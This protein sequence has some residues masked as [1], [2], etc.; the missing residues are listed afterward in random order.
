[1]ELEH[2]SEESFLLEKVY[3]S[4]RSSEGLDLDL[5]KDKELFKPLHEKWI[6]DGFAYKNNQNKVILTS[7][8]Y[9]LLDSLMNDLF[10]LNLV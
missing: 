3:M 5:I 7:E 4:I 6:S 10:S 1:M 2:L 8:G 9:L